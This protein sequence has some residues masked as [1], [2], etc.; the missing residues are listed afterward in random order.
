MRKLIYNFFRK[1]INK[2]Y[3]VWGTK[4]EADLPPEF[5]VT[6]HACNKLIERFKCDSKK[7]HKI[8]LKAWRSE[9]HI[10]KEFIYRAKLTHNRGIYKMFNGHIFVFRV[11][12]NNRLGFS[13]KYLVTVFRKSGY[14]IYS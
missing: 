5:I 4:I 8:M 2:H 12:Y 6:E 13:Q 11:R 10:D 14:Q 1:Y 9:E 3:D 7:F